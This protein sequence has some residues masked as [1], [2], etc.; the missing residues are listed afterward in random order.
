[1]T[2]PPTLNERITVS[3]HGPTT[4]PLVVLLHGMGVSGWM[5]EAQVAALADCYRVMVPDLPGHGGSHTVAWPGLDGVA[6]IIA[7]LIRARADRA[8]VVGL[9]LGSYVALRLL[10]RQPEVVTSLAVTGTS[11]RP[12]DHLWFWRPV[13]RVL[14]A[15]ASWDLMITSTAKML[16][17]PPEA[18]ALMRQDLKRLPPAVMSAIY[19]EVFAFHLPD[20]LKTT[21]RPLLAMAGSLEAPAVRDGLAAYRQVPTATLALA[22][23]G[24]HAWNAELPELFNATVRAWLAGDTLP[25]TLEAV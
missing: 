4:G 13:A 15:T 23:G 1:M 17:L 25:A 8:H 5:W 19:D 21:T 20:A 10:A 12:F 18:A 22:P 24:H 11:T 14:A 7:D 3:E 16:Q 6:D 2:H 9:S